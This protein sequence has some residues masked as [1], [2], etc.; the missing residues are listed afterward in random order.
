VNRR[1]DSRPSRTT[2][3]DDDVRMAVYRR[4][5]DGGLEPT[6]A[7]LVA[8]LGSSEEQVRRA[9]DRLAE[10]RHVVLGPNHRILMAHPFTSVPMG[11]AVMGDHTLWWG[12][13]AW[14]SF[15]L[16]HLVPGEP[17]VLV[18]TTCP[19]CRRPLAW[20]V[21][22]DKPPPGREV[23]HFLTPAAHMWEDVLRTCSNQR[24]FCDGACVDAWVA[25]E[26][27]ERGYVMDLATL[28]RLAQGWYAGRLDPGYTRREPA[29]AADYFR[30]VGLEGPFWGL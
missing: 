2:I 1:D 17:E 8:E 27:L 19:N 9:L 7:W 22:R 23:A 14:D 3:Q 12:G 21:R 15:A 30:E 26:D 20:T 16:P 29:A 6:T 24:I 25:R 13:C 11:F 28:W 18:S 5:A 4:F 10:Q